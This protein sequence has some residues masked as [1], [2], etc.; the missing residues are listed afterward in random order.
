MTLEEDEASRLA[1]TGRNHNARKLAIRDIIS[2]FDRHRLPSEISPD[3]FKSIDLEQASRDEGEWTRVGDLEGTLMQWGTHHAG[4]HNVLDSLQKPEQRAILFWQKLARRFEAE[5]DEY[6]DREK[7]LVPDV[8][9]IADNLRF[10][11]DEYTQDWTERSVP[12]EIISRKDDLHK[13]FVEAWKEV[14]HRGGD[15]SSPSRPRRSAAG[16]A[17]ISLFHNL[18]KNPPAMTKPFMIEIFEQ[19]SMAQPQALSRFKT[20]LEDILKRLET[21]DAPDHYRERLDAVLEKIPI[22]TPSSTSGSGFRHIEPKRDEDEPATGP[23]RSAQPDPPTG[24][25]RPASQAPGRRG[26]Q[27]RGTR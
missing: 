11:E 1:I 4:L 7:D 27:K 25:K 12:S 22:K 5:F 13:A 23:S 9:R 2:A 6:D 19:L 10:L 8:A 26:K 17:P 21:L 18:I 3:A 15:V 14:C 24:S 16:H 20:D